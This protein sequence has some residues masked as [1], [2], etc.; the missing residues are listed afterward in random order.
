M[1]SAAALRGGGQSDRTRGRITPQH[2]ADRRAEDLISQVS[3]FLTEGDPV[4]DLE[5]EHQ[6]EVA[7]DAGVQRRR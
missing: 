4:A 2:Q 7:A 6:A 1:G 5:A 3:G